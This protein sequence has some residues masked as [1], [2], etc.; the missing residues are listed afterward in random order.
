MHAPLENYR[1]TRLATMAT[2]VTDSLDEGSTISSNP[3]GA[4]VSAIKPRSE[5]LKMLVPSQTLFQKVRM[6]WRK[7]QGGHLLMQKGV[8]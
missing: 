5:R 6:I 7:L 8:W 3:D 2:F 1:L 4:S